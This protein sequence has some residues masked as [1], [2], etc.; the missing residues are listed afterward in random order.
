MLNNIKN[1]LWDRHWNLLPSKTFAQ[2]RHQLR[3]QLSNQIY[4]QL[5][6]QVDFQAKLR[7]Q[8][9]EDHARP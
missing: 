6:R 4:S 8:L 2:L 3:Y 7:N 5:M 1:R 9:H